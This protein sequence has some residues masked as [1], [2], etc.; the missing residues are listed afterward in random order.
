V[1]LIEVQHVLARLYTDGSLREQFLA[2]PESVGK[3]L[4]ISADEARQLAEARASIRYF[5][6]SLQVKRLGEAGRFLPATRRALGVRY[7]PLFLKYAD[8]P[9]PTGPRKLQEDALRFV[10]FLATHP[11]PGFE[12][13]LLELARFE[14]A[15]IDARAPAPRLLVRFFRWPVQRLVQ[16]D[17]TATM[18]PE[19]GLGLWIRT[20]G[21]KRL[22]HY[23]LRLSWPRYEW[24][25]KRQSKGIH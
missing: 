8:T 5:A 17:G 24:N 20:S 19:W 6:R 18:R 1:G 12:P 22:H 13:W 3:G 10:R 7:G 4:G 15:W 2:D 11:E 14:A 25:V 9:P 23:W 21:R 16:E